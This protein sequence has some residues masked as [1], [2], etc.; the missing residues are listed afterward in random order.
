MEAFLTTFL[1]TALT[2]MGDR[3]QVLM[4]ALA[5]RFH[6]RAKL[7]AGCA[8]ATAANCAIAAYAGHAVGGWISTDALTLFYALSLLF[9]GVGMLAWRRR[10]DVLQDWQTSAFVTSLIGLFVMQL[11]DKGQFIIAATSARQAAWIYPLIGGWCGVM[12]GLL[13]AIILQE[14]LAQLLPTKLIRRAG[15]LFFL[16]L[17]VIFVLKAARMI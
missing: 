12:L 8:I 4:A 6:G 11:G 14:R 5:I 3:T 7:I 15:G 1:F 16:V 10:V 13:P 17:G 9:A 2:Q